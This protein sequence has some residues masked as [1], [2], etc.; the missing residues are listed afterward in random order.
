MSLSATGEVV[1]WEGAGDAV[2]KPL[3]SYVFVDANST[4]KVGA[5]V[6]M[7]RIAEDPKESSIRC[8]EPLQSRVCSV[9][10]LLHEGAGRKMPV[11][12]LLVAIGGGFIACHHCTG[13]CRSCVM[14]C[15]QSSKGPSNPPYH[16]S[17]VPR[18][19]FM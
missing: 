3:P 16:I 11:R 5:I 12:A 14:W 10:L 1:Q 9:E 18:A 4:V 19:A 6:E 2:V 13:H 8:S 7:D 15:D 17:A